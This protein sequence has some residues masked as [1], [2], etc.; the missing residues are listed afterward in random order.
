MTGA[1]LCSR[2]KYTEVFLRVGMILRPGIDTEELAKMLKEDFESDS[3]PR[4]RVKKRGADDDEE[5]EQ[6]PP[7]EQEQE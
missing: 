5:D 4:K 3:Q 1:K 7:E 2:D 6:P